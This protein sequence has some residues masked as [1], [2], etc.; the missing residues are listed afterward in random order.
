[1][2]DLT[3]YDRII[4]S[5]HPMYQKNV[6]SWQ[7][8]SDHYTGGPEYPNKIN[9]LFQGSSRVSHDLVGAN[10][11]LSQYSLESNV[12][13]VIR[14]GRA[15]FV[16]VCAPG[17]DMFAGLIGQPSGVHAE[18]PNGYDMIWEDATL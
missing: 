13:Y 1:M 17:V 12:N 18:I 6:A 5:R 3:I 2:S 11:Y 14:A 10:R 7:Y 9:P 4:A 15:A 16:D 8:F